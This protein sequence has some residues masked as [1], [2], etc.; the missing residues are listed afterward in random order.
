MFSQRLRFEVRFAVAR[1][2]KNP[3][4][5]E[6]QR[7]IR[8]LLSWKTTVSLLDR[9][10]APSWP[11]RL[12]WL[13]RPS[14]RNECRGLAIAYKQPV[15]PKTQ[16]P[17]IARIRRRRQ[18]TFLAR[19]RR[20]LQRMSPYLSLVLLLVPLLLVEPL[21]LV[22]VC[23]AGEG[24]WLAGTAMLVATYAASLL[25]VERLFRVVKPKLMMLGWFARLWMWFAALRNKV[26]P[27]ASKTSLE[28]NTG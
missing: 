10:H 22:A 18:M 17:L 16:M 9:S 8:T 11:G 5:V 20:H 26:I 15:Q 3:L 19:T 4:P 2:R 1:S 24:H 27:W 7:V 23:V 28:A 25:L 21:K 14:G 6:G 12:F 13:G